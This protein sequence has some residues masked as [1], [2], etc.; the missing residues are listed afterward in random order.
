MGSEL[1][2]PVGN[3]FSISGSVED[4]APKLPLLAAKE[5]GAGEEIRGLV[6]ENEARYSRIDPAEP[7]EY[8]R[9]RPAEFG[10]TLPQEVGGGV[11]RR[12]P[13]CFEELRRTLV[14]VKFL[15]VGE[16]P[17]GSRHI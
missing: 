6:S 16:D 8:C 15:C 10:V 5:E 9:E 4:L 12:C 2:H 14:R 3:N 7:C 1:S 11:L 17:S 13:A